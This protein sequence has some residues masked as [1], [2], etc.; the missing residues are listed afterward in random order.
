M[1]DNDSLMYPQMQAPPFQPQAQ[2]NPYDPMQN[3]MMMS[4]ATSDNNQ[5]QVGIHF[6]KSFIVT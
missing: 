5:Q 3:Q 4:C 6:L 1:M 2:Q